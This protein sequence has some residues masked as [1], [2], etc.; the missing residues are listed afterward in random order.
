MNY[1][2]EFLYS[3]FAYTTKGWAVVAVY[4]KVLI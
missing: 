3:Y 2:W 4:R 1:R